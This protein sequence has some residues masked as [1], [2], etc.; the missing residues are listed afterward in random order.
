[1]V[2][3]AS[4]YEYSGYENMQ[5]FFDQVQRTFSDEKLKNIC[6]DINYIRQWPPDI[7]LRHENFEGCE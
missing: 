2:L 4:I 6:K 7:Y 5:N 1:M 3:Q